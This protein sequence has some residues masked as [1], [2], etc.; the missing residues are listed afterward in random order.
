MFSLS[1]FK[2]PK[3]IFFLI[4]HIFLTHY[5]QLLYIFKEILQ[6]KV[7]LVE[8]N[9]TNVSYER[10]YLTINNKKNFINFSV[11]NKIINGDV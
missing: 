2:L 7:N 8:K 3:D 6:V 9:I 4:K 10:G 11:L 1:E 5:Q